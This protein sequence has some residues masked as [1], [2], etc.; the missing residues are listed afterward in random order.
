MD[1]RPATPET[2]VAQ[3]TV[4][5]ALRE[6]LTS[7][8]QKLKALSPLLYQQ[9]ENYNQGAGG[10]G[11]DY[12]DETSLGDHSSLGSL[13]NYQ[14]VSSSSSPY[15]TGSDEW[16]RAVAEVLMI[17]QEAFHECDYGKSESPLTTMWKRLLSVIQAGSGAAS[18]GGGSRGGGGAPQ[19][20]PA[21]GQ[22]LG[23]VPTSEAKSVAEMDHLKALSATVQVALG[24]TE[25]ALARYEEARRLFA[26]AG[27]I[28]SSLYTDQSVAMVGNLTLPVSPILPTLTPTHP[29][30]PY[31]YYPF[32][33]LSPPSH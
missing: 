28:R 15:K 20:A 17:S 12:M 9:G 16:S 31:Y 22:G 3:Q 25:L 21:S 1:G 13:E 27:A 6:G 18:R 26:V 10:E 29:L 5:N 8:E 7:S 11:D 23:G 19:S 32:P 33:P 2:I 30:I 4:A 24:R 14:F